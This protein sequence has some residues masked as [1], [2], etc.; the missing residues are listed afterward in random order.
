MTMLTTV[1]VQLP[2]RQAMRTIIAIIA[3]ALFSAPAIADKRYYLCDIIGNGSEENSYRVIV[4][5]H[6]VAYVAVIPSDQYTGLPLHNWAL[7]RVAAGSHVNIRNICDPLPDYPMDGKVNGIHN[8]T[9][10][11]MKTDIQNRTGQSS[12]WVDG[13]DGYREVIRGLGKF[14]EP[15][16]DENNFDVA[17]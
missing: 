16:F 2:W 1:E 4:A 5:N 7:T 15:T 9:R 17:E 3:I 13:V 10:S 6:G 12:A 8:A 11:K 14:L